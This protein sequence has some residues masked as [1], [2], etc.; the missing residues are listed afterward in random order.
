MIFYL[1]LAFIFY[2]GFS[3]AET[4]FIDPNFGKIERECKKTSSKKE[5]ILIKQWHLSPQINTFKESKDKSFPQLQNQT[6]IYRQLEEWIQKHQIN[7]IIAEGC[8]GIIDDK[9]DLTINGWNIREL[10]KVVNEARYPE[11]ISSIPLKLEAKFNEKLMTVCGDDLSL[12]KEN[13]LAFSDARGEF[14]FLKKCIDLK[15]DPAKLKTYLEGAIELYKLPK[16]TNRLEVV[17]RLKFEL[18]K[19]ITKILETI[20][21]R[22]LKVIEK[23]KESKE[24]KIAVIFGGSHIE[25]LFKQLEAK[26]INCKIITPTGYE[27]QESTLIESLNKLLDSI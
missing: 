25:G 10:K 2:S 6:S 27:D 18:K 24:N 8:E 15:Y 11:I 3:F 22:N 9:S 17:K 21:K 14:G 23:V 20:E 13:N 12:I 16:E 19:S 5:V 26:G 1:T 4:T 7:E